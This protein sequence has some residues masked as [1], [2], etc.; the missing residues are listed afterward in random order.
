MAGQVTTRTQV[1]GYRFHLK[2]MDH[3]LVRGDARMLADPIRSQNR[4][5]SVG[6]VLAALGLAACGILAVLKPLDKLSGS[7]I[8]VGRD[9]QGVYVRMDDTFHPVT[10]LASAKLIVGGGEDAAVI[11]EDEL[12]AHPRGPL[13]GILGVPAVHAASPG[14]ESWAV[15]DTMTGKG[16]AAAVRTSVIVAAEERAMVQHDSGR[17]V[18]VQAEDKHYLL[19]S[20]R[21]SVV[22]LDDRE[23]A[24]ALGLDGMRPRLVSEALLASIPVAPPLAPPVIEG[25]GEKPGFAAAGRKVGE[26]FKVNQAGETQYFVVLRE[27]VQHVGEAVA[28]LVRF[29]DSL[30][31]GAIPVMTPDV[32]SGMPT[33]DGIPVETYPWTAPE[34]VEGSDVLCA[35]WSVAGEGDRARIVSGPGVP[36]PAGAT[37]IERIGGGA[38]GE[39]RA[40]EVYV[41]PGAGRYVYPVVA[42]GSEL[43]AGTRSALPH[44]VADTGIRYGIPSA[45]DAEALGVEVAPSPVPWSVLRLL[46]PGPALSQENALK[47][48]GGVPSASAR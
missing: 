20:G 22:D 31:A 39:L 12:A 6:L 45:R 10:N 9:T 17:A 41:P 35:V 25:R 40:D 48:H 43:P 11:N 3:A 1:S 38:P 14:G 2:R 13:L 18:L 42:A 15:C 16:S 24:L 28:D 19:H 29:T 27:G 47:A 7:L 30:G 34:M 32:L 21:R 36:V 8:V 44:Y 37:M 5:L 23:V 26:V 33:V 4:A 46:E